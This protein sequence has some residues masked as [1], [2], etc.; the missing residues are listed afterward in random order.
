MLEKNPTLN[1]ANFRPDGIILG[2]GQRVNIPSGVIVK[3][4]KGRALIATSK[5]GIASKRGI[6]FLASTVD[7][8]YSG[9]VH[10]NLVNTSNVEASIK[11]G[12]KIIQFVMFH[13]DCEE[14]EYVSSLAELYPEETKR[15]A[16]GFG[17][18]GT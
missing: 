3:V 10:I 17:S 1:E 6:L 4:P 7:F 14:P 9:E 13:I 16:N 5:S 15:G 18:T 2:P 8:G 11:Y 12:E